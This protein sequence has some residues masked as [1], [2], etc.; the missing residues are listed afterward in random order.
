[1]SSVFGGNEVASSLGEL[2]KAPEGVAGEKPHE[3]IVIIS[4]LNSIERELRRIRSFTP[5]YGRQF[6]RLD[7]GQATAG[8]IFNAVLEG[9]KSGMDWY[10][11]R[12]IVSVAGASAAG[13]LAVYTGQVVDES[14]LVDFLAALTG[15]NP[16]RGR[17]DGSGG[18][19][20]FIY[21]GGPVLVSLSGIVAATAV[22]IRLQGREVLSGA[23][24]ALRPQSDY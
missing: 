23:D 18:S 14:S 2:G 1:M 5:E 7:G 11:E 8:G 3:G 24:P 17:L 9:P 12:L 20:Y 21:G 19:P 4:V 6:M 16:S 22:Q 13:V 10:L 15:N